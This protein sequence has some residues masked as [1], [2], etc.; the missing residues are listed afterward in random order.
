M[1]YEE[2]WTTLFNGKDFAGWVP[3]VQNPETKS[4]KKYRESEIAEQNTFSI[5]DGMVVTT[6]TPNGYVRTTDVYDNFV[7]HVEVRFPRNGNSGVLI[8]V[9]RDEVWPKGIECQLY[10]GHMGRIFPIQGATL[11]R[12]RD[13]PLGGEAARGVEHL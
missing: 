12:R 10:Q 1:T 11:D 3:V 8:H 2:G 5:E 7:F 13:D 9:Q 4:A 6:G